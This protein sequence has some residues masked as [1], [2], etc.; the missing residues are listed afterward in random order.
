MLV[1]SRPSETL[2][3]S[4]C[5][6]NS[7]PVLRSFLHFG[8][9]YI[10]SIC[11]T[12]TQLVARYVHFIVQPFFV[13]RRSG[14]SDHHVFSLLTSMR[15]FIFSCCVALCRSEWPIPFVL[16]PDTS[17]N[18]EVSLEAPSKPLPEVSD[19]IGKLEAEREAKQTIHKSSMVRAF[20]KELASAR[21]RIAA[22]L[23]GAGHQFAGRTKHSQHASF[24]KSSAVRAVGKACTRV[25]PS[26]HCW[27]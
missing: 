10:A 2:H 15:S 14:E 11:C 12:H 16:S 26:R 17:P 22:V 25:C 19:E 23:D 13:N 9:L 24:L 6:E 8:S 7:R 5:A 4:C 27:D 3:I 21:L 18:V 20:N 1:C